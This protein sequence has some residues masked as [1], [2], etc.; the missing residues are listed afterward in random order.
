MKKFLAC[1]VLI[2][3]LFSLPANINAAPD[4]PGSIKGVIR[5]KTGSSDETVV[6]PNAKLT[7][8]NK[9]IAG[10]KL[11]AV[12]D[13]AGN[14]I[15]DSVPAGLY[16][17]TVEAANLPT[18]TR[19]IDL[20]SGATLV[21]DVDLTVEVS[22]Q[23][24]I[25]DEEG[26]GSVSETTT[27]NIVRAETL[28]T[29]P[30]R[31]DEYQSALPLTPGVVRDANN[32]SYIK[33]SR[34]GN[35]LYKVNGADVTDPVSGEPVFEIPLEAVANIQIEENPYSAEFGQFTGGVTELQ[36]KGGGDKFKF[37]IA[38]F[39]PT[40]HN[41]VSSRIDSF[42]PRITFSGPIKKDKLYFLQS[43]EYRFRRD[44]VPNLPEPLNNT[45]T[46]RFS[47]FTQ[48][49]Y[50]INGSNQLKFNFALYPQKVRFINL[51]T[52]NP[53]VTTPNVK[54]RGFLV[55][56]SEQSV[57]KNNS[58]LTSAFN[59]N[60]SEF[61]VF[62][63]GTQPLT[64]VSDINRGNYFADTRRRAGRFQ[65]QETY[66]FAPFEFSGKH[67]LKIGLEYDHTNVSSKQTY[68]PIFF[69]RLDSTLAQV[70]T[71]TQPDRRQIDYSEVFAFVQDRYVVNQK[72]T[73]DF[74]LR[75]DYDGVSKENN[76]SPR[77]SFLFTPFK[78]NR[79]VIRGGVGIF[80]DRTLP[81]AGY[82][83]AQLSSFAGVPFV[84]QNGVPERSVTTYAANGITPVSSRIYVNQTVGDIQTPRS[85]RY[86]VHLDQGITKDLIVR[87]GYLQRTGRNDLIVQPVIFSPA[88]GANQ[89]S[90]TGRSRYR[91]FQA[92]A[93]YN[94]V[95]YGNWNVS[96][97]NAKA[98][99]DLNT[100]DVVIDQF[101]ALNIR[102][103][104]YSLLPFDV[105]HRF[106][107]YGQVDLPYKIRLAPLFEY[108]TGFPFS[109]V[110]DRLEYVG[111]RNRA[112]RF[113]DFLSLDLTLTKGVR[114]PFFEKYLVRV[115]ASLFNVTNHFNPRDVQNN[116][117]NPNYGTFYNSLDFGVKARFDV[118]F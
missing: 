117:F 37:Q 57:F 44:Y 7:L 74:G 8:T 46:E 80:Y 106:L 62:G 39:F 90:S 69:R 28:K 3:F 12:S 108:R 64:Y 102:P 10:F 93:T 15:F 99:G 83:S 84:R 48:I 13:D 21:V 35:S 61:D 24:E 87:V 72:L 19:D 47:S 40:L 96:Y 78:G 75:Y 76:L 52:F 59:F 25:R 81:V 66:Y 53:A 101:P 118:D 114:F 23:V 105:K 43:F 98:E 54:Q 20:K 30:F 2:V 113:P 88:L 70:I 109:A 92:L 42:R 17:L 32:N 51:N 50:R 33:G 91:E 95:K 41:V 77:F 73:L 29:Q 56:L 63:Q 14:F 5:A 1:S 107:A 55:S 36:S 85:V 18:A 16:T 9:N 58:F 79:T 112:G 89:L 67:S 65:L 94:N 68:N 45:V 71:F 100:A 103:N 111:G 82:Y 11:E 60:N 22:A 34:P 27:S 4:N 49:D 38:R 31:E 6:V 115:G 110:N 116:I 104:Q 86:S 26:L 97:T